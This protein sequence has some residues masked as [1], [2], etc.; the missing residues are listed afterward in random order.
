MPYQ[1]DAGEPMS[2]TEMLK[3]AESLK[4]TGNEIAA[5]VEDKDYSS[6]VSLIGCMMTDGGVLD[7]ECMNRLIGRRRDGAGGG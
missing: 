7:V 6:V 3:L 5:F 2:Q 1:P 4:E